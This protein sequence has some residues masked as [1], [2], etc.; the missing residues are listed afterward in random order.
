MQPW[1]AGLIFGVVIVALVRMALFARRR[2]RQYERVA[3]EMGLDYRWDDPE[4]EK[5]LK[6]TLT[7]FDHEDLCCSAIMQGREGN[8]NYY[9][10]NYAYYRRKLNNRRDRE[11]VGTTVCFEHRGSTLPALRVQPNRNG[12]SSGNPMLDRPSGFSEHFTVEANEAGDAPQGL[13]QKLLDFLASTPERRWALEAN[14][15]WLA[16]WRNPP[17]DHQRVVAP[18]DLRQFRDDVLEIYRRLAG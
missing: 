6:G 12:R 1:M 8:A 2:I 11:H 18:Q 14:G 10:F 5:R 13:P 4:L 17:R 15:A 3:G 7:V 9:V 16:V